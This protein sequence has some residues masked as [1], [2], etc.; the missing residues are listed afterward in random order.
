MSNSSPENENP[1]CELTVLDQ[2]ID[3]CRVCESFVDGFR[4]PASM[5]RGNPG[6]VMVVG[7]DPG[8]SE[9]ATGRAFSGASGKRLDKWL[10]DSGADQNDPRKGV[11]TTSVIKCPA[12]NQRLF[13]KMADRCRS[14]LDQQISLVAPEIVIS[15][16]KE[17]YRFLRF[18]DNEYSE[19]VCRVY[20]PTQFPRLFSQSYRLL[21]WPHPSPRSRWLNEERNRLRL[22]RSFE[23]LRTM[24][25]S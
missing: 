1:L 2:E 17:A 19:A 20:D 21:V 5:D 14:F 18:A 15:L 22:E 16:G 8:N 3:R 23:D 12:P 13:L 9:Q 10:I 11:Y 25:Y 4:K 6:R 7:Q 24:I